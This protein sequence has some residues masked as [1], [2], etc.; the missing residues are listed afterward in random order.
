MQTAEVARRDRLLLSAGVIAGIG[1]T[2]TSCLLAALRTGFDVRRHA[3]SLLV[4]G[5]WGWV[6]TVDFVV[7]GVLVAA[8]G[9]G[10]W[11]LAWPLR[12]GVLA[13]AGLVVYGI[14][15]GVIVGLNPPP[16]VFGFPPGSTGGYGGYDKLSTSAK[17][18]GIGGM[19]GFLA[20][21]VACFAFARYFA[22]QE[23]R[24][25]S[26]LSAGVGIS[27]LAVCAYLGANASAEA[28]SFDYLPTWAGSVL[29]WLYLAAVAGK[30][31]RDT[32]AV[33]G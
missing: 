17:I 32:R 15:A 23:Q 16:P 27:V 10:V 24:A 20:V 31:W 29:L 28:D 33:A 9:L 2:A 5:D 22:R 11:R 21:T 26:V 25:W 19:V 12:S 18:H 13:A 30:L 14:G 7:F 1:M 6:Q 8:F 3:N 4:L